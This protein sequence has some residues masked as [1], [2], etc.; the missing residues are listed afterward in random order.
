ME[1]EKEIFYVEHIYEKNNEE[2]I[3]FIGVFSSRKNAQDAINILIL[4]PG[5]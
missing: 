2:E 4:K 3:K 5:F 1:K